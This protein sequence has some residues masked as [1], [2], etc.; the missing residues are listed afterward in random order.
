MDKP[1]IKYPCEW[2]YTVIGAD[3]A[4]LRAAAAECFCGKEHSV[5]F[6]KKSKEGNYVSLAIKTKVADQIERDKLFTT[7]G[8]HPAIKIV[9]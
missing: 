7:L 6:S 9:L 8:K 5:E 1:E 2:D 4:L 3:E